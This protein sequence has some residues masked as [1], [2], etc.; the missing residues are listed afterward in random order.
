MGCRRVVAGVIGVVLVGVAGMPG[1]RAGSGSATSTGHEIVVDGVVREYLR[2][3]P[4]AVPSGPRPLVLVLHGG[5]VGGLGLASGDQ[6]EADSNPQAHW[7]EIADRE[8]LIVVFPTGL[9]DNWNDCRSDALNRAGEDVTS[10]ADDVGFLSAVIDHV[11]ADPALEVDLSR[12][13]ATGVSN[14]GLMSYRLAFELSDR[15]AAAGA[16]VA[17][18]P[19]DPLGEC[20]APTQPV[21][22]AIMNGDE[23]PLMPWDGGCVSGEGLGSQCNRGRVMSTTDTVAFWTDHNATTV[24]HDPIEYPD[25]PHWDR[26]RVIRHDYTG[27]GDGTEVVLFHVDGGGHSMPTLDHT[28]LGSLLGTIRDIEGADL[29]EIGYSL[30]GLAKGLETNRDIEGAEELWA[31]MKRHTRSTS[32]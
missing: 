18:L 2:Y 28:G 9:D 27:G 23:D 13:Y 6:A 22:V 3:V 11:D 21:T 19:V 29:I 32:P 26:S 31:V 7:K 10:T 5:F 24:N 1:A 8:G 12:V 20:T 16:V 15:I 30:W 17:N 4:S 14:G 25:G